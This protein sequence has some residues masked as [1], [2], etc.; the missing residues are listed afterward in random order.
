MRANEIV[1]FAVEYYDYLFQYDERLSYSI[2]WQCIMTQFQT[3]GM[4]SDSINVLQYKPGT[5]IVEIEGP[6]KQKISIDTLKANYQACPDFDLRY[7]CHGWTF[8][9]GKFLIMD[10]YIPSIL[11]D[12]YVEVSALDEHDIVMFKCNQQG[13]WIHSCKKEKEGGYSHKNGIKEFKKVDSLHEIMSMDEYKDSTMYFFRRKKRDC[14]LLCL[15]VKKG[16]TIN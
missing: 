6:E 2:K 3:C 11:A 16:N 12:E 9:K 14:N 10:Q 15:G 1:P 13:T 8:T 5:G 4:K 7:N